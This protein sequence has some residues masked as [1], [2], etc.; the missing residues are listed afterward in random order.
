MNETTSN[1]EKSRPP[2]TRLVVLALLWI[3][4][5]GASAWTVA[6]WY[7]P[8][9]LPKPP[10]TSDFEN[11]VV[12]EHGCLL[13][14]HP[15]LGEYMLRM[16]VEQGG[17]KLLQIDEP[18][19][20][21]RGDGISRDRRIP[22]VRAEGPTGQPFRVRQYV[23]RSYPNAVEYDVTWKADETDLELVVAHRF[24]AEIGVQGGARI[25]DDVEFKWLLEPYDRE[26]FFK[27]I[28]GQE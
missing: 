17:I 21:N 8:E 18:F 20:I 15:E 26:E 19:R 27:Q 5:L 25:S 23:W 16:W 1:L 13:P 10:P 22:E 2:R 7:R 4:V 9:K 24:R 28:E 11:Y 6:R 12:V 3:V 14:C